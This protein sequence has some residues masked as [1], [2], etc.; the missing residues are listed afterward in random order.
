MFQKLNDNT[1]KLVSK[2][3][4]L[5]GAIFLTRLFNMKPKIFFYFNSWNLYILLNIIRE[6]GCLFDI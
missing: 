4:Y 3:N 2:S 6:I 1:I 5:L